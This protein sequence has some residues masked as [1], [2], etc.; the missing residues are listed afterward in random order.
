MATCGQGLRARTRKLGVVGGTAEPLG[1]GQL[2]SPKRAAW[3]GP[4][5]RSYGFLG[6]PP[7]DGL[8][9]K[10]PGHSPPPHPFHPFICQCHKLAQLNKKP[11]G[12]PLINYIHSIQPPETSSRVEESGEWTRGTVEDVQHSSFTKSK[13]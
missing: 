6:Q 9:G 8:S 11:R 4:P 10:G 7:G 12:S 5:K 1:R 2:L 3:R 13:R